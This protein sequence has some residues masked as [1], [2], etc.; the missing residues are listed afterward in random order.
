MELSGKQRALAGMPD[1][2]Y[3]PTEEYK[4]FWKLKPLQVDATYLNRLDMAKA[5]SIEYCP[6]LYFGSPVPKLVTADPG[7]GTFRIRTSVGKM[8]LNAAGA[9]L[10]LVHAYCSRE[11]AEELCEVVTKWSNAGPQAC[12][13]RLM[14]AFPRKD[15]LPVESPPTNAEA[16]WA[17]R[18]SGLKPPSGGVRLY[19]L[20]RAHG[21]HPIRVSKGSSNGLPT[22]GS[23]DDHEAMK[24]CIALSMGLRKDLTQVL[25]NGGYAAMLQR[26]EVLRNSKPLLFTALGACKSDPYPEDKINEN[27]MRFYAV[28]PRAVAMT[29]QQAAQPMCDAKGNILT[30]P[31]CMS[32]SGVS[33]TNGGADKLVREL[34]R[35]FEAKG[36]AYT[37]MGDDSIVF[38]RL[39]DG[40][41]LRFALDM[42]NY[43]L[44]QRSEV[45]LE[46]HREISTV[47]GAWDEV[48]A[49][50][51]SSMARKKSVVMMGS[52]HYVFKH[53]SM[54]GTVLQSEVNTPL[55]MIFVERV[56]ARLTEI[57]KNAPAQSVHE[58]LE[59]V[60]DLES[61]KLGLK[62][63][64]E[65]ESLRRCHDVLDFTEESPF[66]YVGYRLHKK[67]GVFVPEAD[68]ARYLSK[69]A[70]PAG[71]YLQDKN[72]LF[73]LEAMRLGGVVLSAGIM[74]PELAP[75]LEAMRSVALSQLRVSLERLDEDADIEGYE[76]FVEV[77][78]LGPPI[79]KS[80]LGLYN[81]VLEGNDRIWLEHKDPPGRDETR[82]EL[83]AP[84][85]KK[86][87][88][89]PVGPEVLLTRSEIVA[90]GAADLDEM[91]PKTQSKGVSLDNFGRPP[92]NKPRVEKAN[93]PRRG[94][95]RPRSEQ[96]AQP[97]R[98]SKAEAIAQAYEMREPPPAEL[99]NPFDVEQDEGDEGYYD[100]E[101]EPDQGALQEAWEAQNRIGTASYNPFDDL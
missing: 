74:T 17:V 93:E 86:R 82:N 34:N 29:I 11:I 56:L 69:V 75:S 23:S 5:S 1:S 3:T 14:Q 35:R 45:T 68:W 19:D 40:R 88:N 87:T 85:A 62:C 13:G 55:M 31:E 57:P 7:P 72:K 4:E 80:F 67:G 94:A 36:K 79:I 73:D 6:K 32:F 15:S 37:C 84:V 70:F 27:K 10:P 63:K 100:R 24:T 46:V 95:P 26:I 65:Q 20:T 42:S 81:A 47:L 58:F 39:E 96:P 61:A 76:H 8:A 59:D 12:T 90:F 9:A 91:L 77:S 2:R 48:S 41:I 25:E 22:M 97:Q 43:D 66:L 52:L 92:S 60:V 38:F 101:E 83:F 18:A 98:L 53:A 21:D 99:G 89:K 64:L 33:L 50:L 54:S 71:G 44:T 28:Q 78:D 30:D 49:G 16:K 51:W